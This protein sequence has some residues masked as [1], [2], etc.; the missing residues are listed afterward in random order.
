MA[1]INREGLN[2]RDDFIGFTF[3]GRHSSEFNIIQVS[4]SS[5]MG[6][7]ILPSPKDTT[8]QVAGTDG[9]YYYSSQYGTKTFNLNLAFNDL[10]EE[11]F[12]AMQYWLADKSTGNLIFDEEPY[13]AWDVKINAAPQFNFICFD[14]TVGGKVIRVYKGEGKIS[15]ISY[16]IIA[17]AP[18]PFLEAYN[19]DFI[20]HMN[21]YDI[22]AYNS[23]ERN[24][25]NKYNTNLANGNPPH[26]SRRLLVNNQDGEEMQL[27]SDLVL[28]T[29]LEA[30]SGDQASN[31][32]TRLVKWY[33]FDQW[34][35][36]S[37]I[38]L[39][40]ELDL[41][42]FR[43]ESMVCGYYVENSS[44]EH[45]EETGTSGNGL[46]A[47]QDL[48]NKIYQHKRDN[49]DTH[50]PYTTILTG[51]NRAINCAEE[52]YRRY[53]YCSDT[54]FML[55]SQSLHRDSMVRNYNTN[56]NIRKEDR[57]KKIVLLD[58]SKS[59]KDTLSN[60]LNRDIIIMNDDYRRKMTRYYAISDTAAI[61]T[62]YHYGAEGDYADRAY[63][64]D[65]YVSNGGFGTNHNIIDPW[66]GKI[67][68][69]R[70]ITGDKVYIYNPGNYKT[71]P[72][73]I[74]TVLD[75]RS[76][77]TRSRCNY[78]WTEFSS[79][80][81]N[82]GTQTISCDIKG[83][84]DPQ[85]K[86]N[87]EWRY[88]T[89]TLYPRYK[90][91]SY[92]LE[93]IGEKDILGRFTIDLMKLA[94]RSGRDN[95]RDTGTTIT[96][97]VDVRPTQATYVIDCELRLIYRCDWNTQINMGWGPKRNFRYWDGEKEN[98]VDVPYPYQYYN[99]QFTPK[100]EIRNDAMIAGDFFEIPPYELEEWNDRQI[101]QGEYVIDTNSAG[102]GV[103]GPYTK[104]AGGG[105]WADLSIDTD[106]SWI[107]Q[108][109]VWDINYL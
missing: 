35:N 3:K 84:S 57:H 13:K 86:G 20:N 80:Q 49:Y 18:F 109:V 25:R 83:L 5:R 45:K 50:N 61:G 14:E 75:K 101:L 108:R 98:T 88:A 60:Y 87:Y 90:D 63:Y 12:R 46:T 29:R 38:K 4:S 41:A 74:I 44:G 81:M 15:F 24:F 37:K 39:W 16:S 30:L 31:A 105:H 97:P 62:N 21:G 103:L 89:F 73:I 52:R 94:P 55:G 100:N 71:Y 53:G 106:N 99:T 67:G 95:I 27:T 77:I 104:S 34:K 85:W 48:W 7:E 107:G 82:Q 8:I 9:A 65:T 69:S 10:R 28:D 56:T 66:A 40:E 64:K 43:W 59:K 36:A 58:H 68:P 76:M 70:G 22:S 92:K 93:N 79:L 78:P 42:S 72:K 33:N 54:I 102:S 17:K 96:Y 6:K 91:L 23:T 11:D 2:G 26:W 19:W 32:P 51:K 47:R 1:M